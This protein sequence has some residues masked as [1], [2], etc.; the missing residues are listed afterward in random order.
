MSAAQHRG[1]PSADAPPGQ[2][3]TKPRAD[4]FA[5]DV[6]P[7]R[8]ARDGLLVAA[9]ILFVTSIA[10]LLLYQRAAE[11]QRAEVRSHLLRLTHAAASVVDG[12]LHRTLVSPEQLDSEAYN[13]ILNPL[14]SFLRHTPDV[15][16]VYTAVLRDDGVHF[17]VDSALPV[18]G[19]GDGVIDQAGLFERYD[20]ADPYM[21]V[22][23][24]ENR[25]LTTPAP[26]SD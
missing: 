21:L 13:R 25:A 22:A 14:R 2:E 9:A 24:R 12:D 11:A 17:V 1:S 18:D 23:L 7:I 26:Y 15:K 8:P 3:A 4:A 16:Y 20:D 6:R 5:P 19:D 10:A